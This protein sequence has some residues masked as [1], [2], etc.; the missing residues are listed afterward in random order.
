MY[1]R[2][3][4]DHLGTMIELNNTLFTTIIINNKN[5]LL[6]SSSFLNCILSKRGR[7]VHF[8]AFL[9]VFYACLNLSIHF[10]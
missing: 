2:F 9:G 4:R 1:A 5:W 7:L 6:S 10:N 3:V 8:K